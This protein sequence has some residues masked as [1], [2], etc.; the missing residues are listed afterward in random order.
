MG[1]G[2]GEVLI[3][4]SMNERQR[5]CI[6]KGLAGGSPVD[7]WKNPRYNVE[8]AMGCSSTVSK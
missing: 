7:C 3:G 5:A 1:F 4:L 8:D 2:A 6:S